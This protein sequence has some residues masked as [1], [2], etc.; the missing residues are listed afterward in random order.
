MPLRLLFALALIFTTA[1]SARAETPP[2]RIPAVALEVASTLRDSALQQD[3]AW[4]I[5]ESLTTEVGPRLAGTEGDARA[6]AWAVAKFR[7]LG[8]DEVRTEPVSFPVWLRGEES[9]EVLSPFPQ[10]L[11]LT[12]LGGSI[13]TEGAPLDAEIV[14]FE[15]LDALRAVPDDSLDGRI[16]FISTRTQRFRDGRGYGLS[17]GS[18]VDGAS[19]A[20]SKGASALLIRS[21]GTSND[22]FPHTGNMRYAE[23][24]RRIPAAAVSNPDADLLVNML[25]REQ[26]VTVRIRMEAATVGEYTSQNVIG[27]VRGSELPDEVVLIGGHLDSW[28]LGTGAIDDGAGVAITMAAGALIAALP[29]RPKRTIRVVAFANEEQ[30]LIGARQY[31]ERH[32]ASMHQHLIGAESDFGAG[33]IYGLRSNAP[34]HAWPAIEQI[35]TVLAPLGI[36]VERGVGG[37]GPDL[38]PLVARGMIWAQLAQDG[39]DYFDYH[40]TPNDTLDKIDP[41]ALRQQVAAYAAFAWM[42]AEAEGEFGSK[43][44]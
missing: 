3:V 44:P 37:P 40:H 39:T 34:D 29:Q 20:A 41:I 19:I 1:A 15:T 33:R 28:D 35:G 26:P 11:A 27:E 42:A 30:G 7:E 9:G 24:S 13:G 4:D 5:V 25:R 16:A 43:E 38:I 36:E 6:V 22:R 12:A 14:H 2:T 23:G 32:A 10:R 18:R 21:I 8:F 31:A 17:V